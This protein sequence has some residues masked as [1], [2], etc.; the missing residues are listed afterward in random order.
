MSLFEANREKGTSF[1][2]LHPYLLKH[3]V[4]HPF[5]SF[6]PLY[7]YPLKHLISLSSI[8]LIHQT[9]YIPPQTSNQSIHLIHP[10]SS[11]FIHTPTSIYSLIHS[12]NF[13]PLHLYPLKYLFSHPFTSFIPLH[14]YPLKYLFSHPFI[15][16][17]PTSST[18]SIVYS[19]IHSPHSSHFSLVHNY[20]SSIFSN[21][22]I[23]IIPF[24][25]DPSFFY[26]HPSPIILLPSN[27]SF[28]YR[29]TVL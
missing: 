9:S 2:P 25:P 28:Y 18:P 19:L 26:I 23:S 29:K 10:T 21:P 22:F 6:I 16:L 1:I 4:S 7:P 14:P 13:I 11:H 24:H 20:H 8:H 3:P 27:N 5:I 12:P 17:H 15:Q